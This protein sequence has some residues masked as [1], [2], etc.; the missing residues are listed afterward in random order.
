MNKTT[1]A[2]H[3]TAIVHHAAAR[4]N[5]KMADARLADAMA[6]M[7]VVGSAGW[8]ARRI[9]TLALAKSN[10]EA[11]GVLCFNAM[12][13]EAG[14][15]AKLAREA[16]ADELL[17]EGSR[18]SLVDTNPHSYNCGHYPEWEVIAT[19][20]GEFDSLG[21]ARSEAAR[22]NAASAASWAAFLAG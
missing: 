17:A 9:A 13:V 21:D 4:R 6:R 10:A 22:R 1:L 5:M 7:G 20:D 3:A 16:E 8:K 14:W 15:A 12:L 18:W 11:T 19:K 2:N